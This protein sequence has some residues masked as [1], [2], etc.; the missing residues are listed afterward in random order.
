MSPL[1]SV[2]KA[3]TPQLSPLRMSRAL[4]E[5]TNVSTHSNCGNMHKS[6]LNNATM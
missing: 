2:T 1:L 3:S 5:P 6:I 4:P